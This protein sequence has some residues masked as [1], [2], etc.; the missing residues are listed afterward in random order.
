M[1][2]FWAGLLVLIGAFSYG[3]LSTITKLAYQEGFSTAAVI[4]SQM[5]FGFIGFWISW[6]PRWQ[7]VVSLPV[8]TIITL[9]GC[10]CITALTGIFYYLS[11]QTLPASVAVI[12]L[13]QFVWI[14]IVLD[15]LWHKQKPSMYKWIAIILVLAGTFLAAAYDLIAKGSVSISVTGAILGLLSSL[16]YTLFINFSGHMAN[17]VSTLARSTW[18]TT[19]AMLLTFVVFPPVFL[20]DGSLKSGLALWG[21]L[22]GLFG[23]IVPVYLFAKGVPYIG[24][25]MAA[26]LGAIELPTVII[27]SSV[28][29]AE[30]V[31]L[32][33]WMGVLIIFLGIVIS[34][35]SEPNSAENV[36][37]S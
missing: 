12:F 24:T 9:I 16:T 19:G 2:Q 34:V 13:F 6:F 36:N 11:L 29:L 10:G 33:Q 25:G 31:T 30:Q 27:L 37:P 1:T 26:I 22:L 20:I 32:T 7:A 23:M 17:N 15:W 18:I 14:G 28:I 21:G 35:Y 5:L 3:I 8:K 4:G